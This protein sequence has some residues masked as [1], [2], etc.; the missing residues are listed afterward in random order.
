MKIE[1][2]SER[3][4]GFQYSSAFPPTPT[5]KKKGKS[6]KAPK[7]ERTNDKQ[8]NKQQASGNTIE[9]QQQHTTQLI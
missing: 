5:H 9:Q 1:M 6:C 8:T 7:N 2:I 3:E 4:A